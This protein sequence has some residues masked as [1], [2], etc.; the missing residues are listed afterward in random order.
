[1]KH[2]GIARTAALMAVALAL[3]GCLTTPKRNQPLD[4]Y[5]RDAGYRFRNLSPGDNNSD[6]LFLVLTF[7]GGGTRAASFSYGVL[8]KLRDTEIVWEGK[9][10]RLLDEVDV[11]SSVSGGSLTA[12]YYGLFG[13]RV[14]Q[15]FTGK[16]LY[17]DIQGYLLKQFIRLSTR[18][19]SPRYGRTDLMADDFSSNFFEKQTFADLIARDR[20]PYVIINSTDLSIGSR[21]EFTQAQFDLMKS[22]LA[23][24]PVGYAVAASAAF[25]GLLTPMVLRNYSESID[26]SPPQWVL[27]QADLAFPGSH[28]DM[29]T[30][31]HP[32]RPYIHLADGGV[33]DNLG[34]QPVVQAVHR[35]A[36]GNPP[37]PGVAPENVRKFVILTVN[38][39]TSQKVDWDL[40]DKVISVLDVLDAAVGT[41]IGKYSQ[42]EIDS[43]KYYI[44]SL[45]H[46]RDML[47]HLAGCL[48]PQCTGKLPKP[49]CANT[50][51][52]FVEIAF[53]GLNNEPERE[54]LNALPTSFRLKPH[55]VDALR[56]AASTIL[57]NHPDFQQLVSE[58]H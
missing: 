46:E 53:D 47:E 50:D 27:E 37:W 57:D 22:D 11:V 28:D 30:Y 20:R 6:S 4:D 49:A 16:V 3:A 23:S 38:A 48:C 26:Y 33:S 7:S 31:L 18:L 19:M 45:Q 12:A 25:P 2:P 40:K 56:G 43:L 51:F 17:E 52:H 44:Q 39:K 13:E 36:G 5:R 9:R 54:R 10:K 35:L 55:D 58:L 14:F 42:A 34:L 15:D 8:E 41:P 24:Y 32:D 1:M 21:F 29:L